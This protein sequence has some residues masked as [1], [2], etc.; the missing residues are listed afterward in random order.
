MDTY[1][2]PE[3]EWGIGCL[4]SEG[5]QNRPYPAALIDYCCLATI[6]L[7][8]DWTC[9]GICAHLSNVSLD[10]IGIIS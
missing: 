9:F 6:S 4:G 3:T 5:R 2:T 10:K 1:W 8:S 7:R